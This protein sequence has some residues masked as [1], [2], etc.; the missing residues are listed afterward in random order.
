MKPND[1]KRFET[2]MNEV[3]EIFQEFT[4]LQPS[5][6]EAYW[7]VLQ[8]TPLSSFRQ[9]A[10]DIMG[11]EDRPFK[12]PGPAEFKARARIY[13]TAHESP[14]ASLQDLEA[15]RATIQEVDEVF[16][17]FAGTHG[18]NPFIQE[19]LAYRAW[20][21]DRKPGEEYTPRSMPSRSLTDPNRK[22]TMLEAAKA[23][24]LLP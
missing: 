21:K 2:F 3:A 6:V 11:D 1:R 17:T 19:L 13:A 15:K 22:S 24:G 14:S 12:F 10:L 23:H 9:A 4:P 16:T 7:Q 20:Y 5:R 8:Q 18:T